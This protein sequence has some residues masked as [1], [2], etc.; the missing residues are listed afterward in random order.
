MTDGTDNKRPK[1][2]DVLDTRS[3]TRLPAGIGCTR[4]SVMAAI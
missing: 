1:P 4:R 2:G 3:L